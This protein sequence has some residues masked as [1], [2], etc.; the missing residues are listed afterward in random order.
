MA[1]AAWIA[2]AA[3]L[4]IASSGTAT[5]A[6]AD[7]AVTAVEYT[8]GN[9]VPDTGDRLHLWQ[10]QQ[11][12]F[13]VNVE[14]MSST[15]ELCV[16]TSTEKPLTCRQFD[17]IPGESTRLELRVSTLSSAPRTEATLV[18]ELGNRSTGEVT[19]TTRVPV[20]VLAIGGDADGDDLH[21]EREIAVNASPVVADTDGDG[22]DDGAE[23]RVYD[24]DPTVVDTDDDDL[25]DGAEVHSYRTDPTA[26]DTDGD[27]L[28]DGVEVRQGTNPN[29]ADTDGD[30]LE[31]GAELTTYGTNATRIDTDGDGLN[32][33]AEL[34]KYNTDPTVADT[35]SDGLNDGA[36]VGVYNTDPTMADTDGDGL[37]DN[38]EVARGTDPTTA[39]TD[40][41]GLDD[42]TEL[43]VYNTDP[44]AAD[45][46]SDGLN[47][48]LE[49]ER[50]TDPT[51]PTVGS[52]GPLATVLDAVRG[53][54]VVALVVV[55]LLAGVVAL[56]VTVDEAG[57][58]GRRLADRV[59][60]A[61]TDADSATPTDKAVLTN[62]ERVIHLLERN[63]G[64]MLQSE[65]V[66]AADWPKAT[67]SRVL[68]DMEDAGAVT[69]IDVGYGN[70]TELPEDVPQGAKSPLSD[71]DQ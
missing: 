34:R 49:V 4:L 29:A 47:D 12:E 39:D 45:T 54:V 55:G 38:I 25:G 37:D 30:G 65:M 51:E 26:V 28:A 3:I 46:D 5:V 32:D 70:L 63:G 69:R 1:D 41:D 43:R 7:A 18:F 33:G 59:G 71:G 21:N 57:A 20:T 8:G 13:T 40:G 62:E 23:V 16:G 44:R 10:S 64:R 2:T 14:P 66:E 15:D 58:W 19:A 24:T 27:G 53:P 6:A 48:G 67:V 22:L 60:L 17:P 42:E 9:A 11:H 61:A 35:D 50:G 31:D 52:P 68:S 56:L 36:E